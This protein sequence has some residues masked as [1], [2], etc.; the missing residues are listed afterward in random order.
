MVRNVIQTITINLYIYILYI[1]YYITDMNNLL[2][3]VYHTVAKDTIIMLPHT[4]TSKLK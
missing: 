4:S 2:L 3:H 1:L